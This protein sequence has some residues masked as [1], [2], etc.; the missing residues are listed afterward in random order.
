MD[1]DVVELQCDSVLKGKFSSDRMLSVI[2]TWIS[3]FYTVYFAKR[4]LC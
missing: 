2:G 4:V 3:K 1:T